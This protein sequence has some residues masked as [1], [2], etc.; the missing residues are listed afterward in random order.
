[1]M[2]FKFYTLDIFGSSLLRRI[3]LPLILNSHS[4][5]EISIISLINK[6]LCQ[7]TIRERPPSNNLK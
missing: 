2:L 6:L 5:K 7:G 4:L 3:K 1:M